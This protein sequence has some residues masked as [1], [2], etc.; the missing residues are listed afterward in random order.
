MLTSKPSNVS[1]AVDKVK[2]GKL[3]PADFAIAYKRGISSAKEPGQECLGVFSPLP[4]PW[5]DW[6][7]QGCPGLAPFRKKMAFWPDL[8]ARNALF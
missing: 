7:S 3:V 6:M 8:R 2:P 1:N 5:T 4:C